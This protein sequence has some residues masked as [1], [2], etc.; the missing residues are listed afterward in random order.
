M[1]LVTH[2][3]YNNAGNFIYSL[4]HFFD[5]SLFEQG[6]FYYCGTSNPFTLWNY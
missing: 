4:L 6:V 1:Q 3:T 5:Y 2:N